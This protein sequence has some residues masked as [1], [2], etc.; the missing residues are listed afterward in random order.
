MES[1]AAED[2]STLIPTTGRKWSEYNGLWGGPQGPVRKTKHKVE[3]DGADGSEGGDGDGEGDGSGSDG[4]GDG[5]GKGAGGAEAEEASDATLAIDD[6]PGTEASL[7]EDDKEEDQDKLKDSVAAAAEAQKAARKAISTARAMTEKAQLL[8]VGTPEREAAMT[9]ADTMSQIADER[10][11]FA[12]EAAISRQEA[13]DTMLDAAKKKA[14]RMRAAQGKEVKK[15]EEAEQKKE[16]AAAAA[17]VTAATTLP[18][19]AAPIVSGAGAGAGAGAGG[20]SEDGPDGPEGLVREGANGLIHQVRHGHKKTWI[21]DLNRDLMDAISTR[22]AYLDKTGRSSATTDLSGTDKQYM[23]AGRKAMNDAFRGAAGTNAVHGALDRAGVIFDGILEDRGKPHGREVSK[24]ARLKRAQAAYEKLR[25]DE[26]AVS[27]AAKAQD[28]ATKGRYAYALT[29]ADRALTADVISLRRTELSQNLA[30]E[31]VVLLNKVAEQQAASVMALAKDEFRGG[32]RKDLEKARALILQA[33][34][35]EVEGAASSTVDQANKLFMHIMERSSS[36]RLSR[37]QAAGGGG[38]GGGGSGGSGGGGGGGGPVPLHRKVAL[39]DDGTAMT[40][41]SPSAEG[42]ADAP[43]SSGLA[44]KVKVKVKAPKPD[45]PPT[46]DRLLFDALPPFTRNASWPKEIERCTNKDGCWPDINTINVNSNLTNDAGLPNFL[47]VSEVSEVREVHEARGGGEAAAGRRLESHRVRAR[48]ER[49]GWWAKRIRGDALGDGDDVPH[50]PHASSSL[51]QGEGGG[52]GTK[53]RRRSLRP[54]GEW[55]VHALVNEGSIFLEEGA[56]LGKKEVGLG[57]I[58]KMVTQELVHSLTTMFTKLITEEMTEILAPN[59]HS[60]IINQ[61]GHPAIAFITEKLT[62]A[63]INALPGLLTFT[64]STSYDALL[65]RF[66]MLALTD[67]MTS[68]LTRALTHTLTP[69]LV[70]TLTVSPFEATYCFYCYYVGI[71]DMCRHCQ[72]T[73]QHT[74]Y[75]SYYSDYY[76]SYYSDYYAD[77]YVKRHKE[78]WK[79]AD[80]HDETW[81]RPGPNAD[82]NYEKKRP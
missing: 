36:Y 68:I 46:T 53:S 18:L 33:E 49:Q 73:P 57:S 9:E 5:D 75:A 67:T 56:D 7:E 47:E 79:K 43:P 31:A 60:S 69:T 28:T 72:H 45:D 78:P 48:E 80:D 25:R 3:E 64:I 52:D 23:V 12:T 55:A 40:S 4:E 41:L 16:D 30:G 19:P 54:E 65:P 70:H 35:N 1:R 13:A 2:P 77:F 21:A 66:M 37:Q 82:F 61:V 59:I 24:D 39:P 20:E 6:Y 62:Y 34:R 63:L 42:G 15:Y 71:K 58:P 74:T 51:S 26:M 29:A 81:K 17:K 76:A 10:V 38:G 22:R 44:A 32:A 14:A 50:V 27:I 11:K 8:K